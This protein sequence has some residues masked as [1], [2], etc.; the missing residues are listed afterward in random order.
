M[1]ALE[2]AKTNVL[3]NYLVLGTLERYDEFLA[4]LEHML[5]QYF[6]GIV[7]L[8]NQKRNFPISTFAI[9]ACG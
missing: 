3:R 5:P 6:K 2:I 4:V 9:S 1:K 8:Y 7:D